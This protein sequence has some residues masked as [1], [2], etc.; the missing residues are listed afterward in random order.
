M[1]GYANAPATVPRPPSLTTR[2]A[3][4]GRRHNVAPFVLVGPIVVFLLFVLVLPIVLMAETSLYQRGQA[5]AIVKVMSLGNYIT[6]L[7]EP[8]YL[9]VLGNSALIGAFVCVITL[10]VCAITARFMV[11]RTTRPLG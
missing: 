4:F 10:I 2:L 1:V 5:G 6:F 7:K 9:K 11:G 3:L 8:V